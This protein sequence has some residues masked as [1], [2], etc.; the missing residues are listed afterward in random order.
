MSTLVYGTAHPPA[1]E[2][3]GHPADLNNAE[4][5]SAELGSNGE[6][7]MPCPLLVEHTGAPVG[8]VEHSWRGARGELRVAARIKQPGAIEAVRNGTMRGLS[9]GTNVQDIG[10]GSNRA[11]DE[12]SIC[13]TPARRNCYIDMI[14]GRKV[15]SRHNAS[16]TY[17][18][19]ANRMHTATTQHQ[20]TLPC[21]FPDGRTCLPPTRRVTYPWTR[22]QPRLS[23]P[24]R[25][26]PHPCPQAQTPIRPTTSRSSKSS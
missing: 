21:R 12:L 20:S 5:E 8:E 24:V 15:L 13:K 26:M 18:K 10:N 16:G 23:R 14:D 3:Y 7:G 4:I 25:R 2:C 9:L 1:H 6:G 22:P 11:V 17:Y 19:R